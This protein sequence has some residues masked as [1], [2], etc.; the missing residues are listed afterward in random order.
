M[1]QEFKLHSSEPGTTCMDLVH[2]PPVFYLGKRE[3]KE[4]KYA[5]KK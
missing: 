1:D 5:R 2:G 3:R 4:E